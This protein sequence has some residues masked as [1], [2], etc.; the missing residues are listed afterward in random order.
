MRFTVVAAL[1]IL[2]GAVLVGGLTSRVDASTGPIPLN[3]NR[4]C[5]ENLVDQ[6]LAAVV[7]HDP[8]RMPFSADVKYTENYQ[9]LQLGDGFWKTAQARGKYTHIFADP[10]FGQVASMGTMMEPDQPLLMSLRLRIELGRITE[11]E[12]LYYKAGGGGPNNIADMNKPHVPESMWFKSIPPAQ[13]LS[14]QELIAVADGYFTG[15][16]KNDG[17]GINRT[18]TYPFTNDCNRIENGSLTASAPPRAKQRP[19]VIDAF[20]LTL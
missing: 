1:A 10:E 17:T 6:Y 14:R 15:L 4:A 13:R 5:L 12:T 9:V 7:A 18:G 19:G 16:Q 2:V 8:K 20:A 3:C 11:V